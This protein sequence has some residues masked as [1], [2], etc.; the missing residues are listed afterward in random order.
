MLDFSKNRPTKEIQNAFQNIQQNEGPKIRWQS[1]PV[2]S[3][4]P[5]PQQAPVPSYSPMAQ[6]PTSQSNF[7]EDRLRQTEN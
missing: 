7:V 1:N 3:Y 5:Q 2:P 4:A 6:A